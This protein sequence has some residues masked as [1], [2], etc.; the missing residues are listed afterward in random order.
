MTA[1]GGTT[2]ERLALFIQTDADLSGIKKTRTEIQGTA[3][4]IKL[5]ADHVKQ[6]L[7]A[8]GGDFDK[9]TKLLERWVATEEKAVIAQQKHAMEMGRA[10]AA[11]LKEDQARQ[12]S[13]KTVE[14]IPP[15][16]R[17]ATNAVGILNQ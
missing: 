5:T 2:D 11:A 4:D 15:A 10:H 14:R 3:A 1:P 9:A 12:A 7:A 6:A 16:L 13:L 8:T 17:G